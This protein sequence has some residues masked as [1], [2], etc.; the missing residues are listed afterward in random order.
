[1]RS[2]DGKEYYVQYES[3]IVQDEKMNYR[4]LVEGYSGTT[5][6]LPNRGMLY[7]NAM[8]FSTHDRDQD[9]IANFNCAA[10]EGGGWWYKDCGAAN[11]NKPWG[12]GDGKGMYWNT[13]PSTLRLDFTEMKIRVK[14]PS[15]PITVCERGM[16]ELTNEPYVL[17]E[18]DTLGKQIRCDA[19]TDGGGW[20]V[21]QRRTN[22]DVDFNKTWNEYRDGFGDLRGNFWLGND[23]ISK[24]TAGPDIYELRVDMHTTDGD[25][26][27]VQYERFTVQDEKMN[28]R[29]FVEGYSGTTGD[30]PNRGMLYHNAMNFS[31]HDRDQDKIA[32]FNCASLEGGG[33]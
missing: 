9:K 13:G 16:N 33:W 28:Y 3:F 22:A 29:L 4:L 25:D 14:L 6:D 12:T 27:Y 19:Q 10:L 17:L 30:L 23:A 24:V 26:Y 11:L 18:L 2:T 8:N 21:I 32:N 1:M 31:T 20:I 15:E 5:G 7:H